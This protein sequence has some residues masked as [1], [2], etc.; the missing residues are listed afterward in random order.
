MVLLK[1][2][3]LSTVL[4]MG[5]HAIAYSETFDEFLKSVRQDLVKENVDATIFDR[6]MEGVEAPNKKVY[7]KLKKQPESIYT[8]TK[9]LNRLASDLR[10]SNGMK[11]KE[12]HKAD[13]LR[14][15]KEY[16]LPKEVILSLWGVESAYGKLQGN[17]KIIPSLASLAY[18]SH[19]RDFFRRELIKAVKIVDDGHIGLDN[20]T[21]SWAGAMGQCQFMPSSFYS[22]AADGNG[23][24]RKDI[25]QTEA[26]VF[27]STANYITKSGWKND[28]PWG[29]AV[30]LTQILPQVKLSSRGLSKPKP[31]SYWYEIGVAHKIKNKGAKLDDDAQARL[32]M[33]DGPSKRAYLVYHNFDVI[34]KW[35]RSSYFAFSVL[36]LADQ[37]AGKERL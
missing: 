5:A 1:I 28:M 23:D 31:L 27:A 2:G 37:L 7:E 34:M 12:L 30:T 17:F 6:A 19:R 21:G 15:E 4:F 11:N 8:F 33:P 18:E 10:I 22:F 16:D 36:T 13:L 14:L 25:W 20:L 32:F 24:G 35:N 3:L 26:D 9:Y 29:E